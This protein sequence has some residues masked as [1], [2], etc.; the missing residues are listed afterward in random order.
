MSHETIHCTSFAVAGSMV[1]IRFCRR[2]ILPPMSQTLPSSGVWSILEEMR[3]L[4]RGSGP[5]RLE[6]AS[7]SK[8]R[9]A[10][11]TIWST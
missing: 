6:A 3:G 2:S 4:G 1:K 7:D 8:S 10:A 9:W 11:W 5:G